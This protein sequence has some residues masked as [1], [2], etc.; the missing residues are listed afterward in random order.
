MSEKLTKDAIDLSTLSIP[1][2]FGR[3]FLP[4]LLGM[5]SI[6]AMT[7]IDG[8]FVGH[9]VGADGIAA[10]NICVPILMV[11]TGEPLETGNLARYRWYARIEE[12]GYQ[13]GYLSLQ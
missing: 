8:I 4:T 13:E 12:D 6:S 1:R 5:L 9:A 2:L 11:V 3:Y 10:I 7:A